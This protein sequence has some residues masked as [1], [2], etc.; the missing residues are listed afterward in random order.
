MVGQIHQ[1]I[2]TAGIKA[3][4]IVIKDDQEVHIREVQDA[5]A[6]LRAPDNPAAKRDKTVKDEKKNE[7]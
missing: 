5:L 4:M 7:L 2:Q 1:D 3:G 6:R